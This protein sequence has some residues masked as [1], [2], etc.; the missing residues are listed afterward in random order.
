MVDVIRF[1]QEY[2][3]VRFVVSSL[4]FFNCL[5]LNRNEYQENFLGI[6]GGRCVR[7]TNLSFS[8]TDIIEIVGSS[9]SLNHTGT[10][11]DCFTM[12]YHY[13]RYISMY[14]LYRRSKASVY[15]RLPAEIA[16]SN[17]VGVWMFVCCVSCVPSG[18]GLRYELITPP[19]ESYQLCCVAVCDVETS[20]CGGRG[21]RWAAAP[22]GEKMLK[23][24][25]SALK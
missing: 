18:R 16:G 5:N 23:C 6:K 1:K 15:G 24:T 20:K 11:T 10:Y 21:P 7:L 13:I 4:G 17:L 8:L 22:Q 25:E 2:L 19:E 3:C 14:N 12:F 9:A